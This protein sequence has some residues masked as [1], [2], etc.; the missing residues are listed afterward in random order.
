M[1]EYVSSVINFSFQSWNRSLTSFGIN[2]L[3]TG[4]QCDALITANGTFKT[5][6]TF[7]PCTNQS[8]WYVYDE[9]HYYYHASPSCMLGSM[10][11]DSRGTGFLEYLNVTHG[12]SCNFTVG[13]SFTW[14]PPAPSCEHAQVDSV[15]GVAYDPPPVMEMNHTSP[16]DFG[17]S[18]TQFAIKQV[19]ILVAMITASCLVVCFARC[20]CWQRACLPGQLRGYLRRKF[21]KPKTPAQAADEPA[22]VPAPIPVIRDERFDSFLN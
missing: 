1:F 13:T 3:K 4:Q 22:E 17:F 10:L 2:P 9:F 14:T 5:C 20:L 7:Q 6:P 8:M 12:A 15:Y 21:T 19:T 11:I 18:K 16:L